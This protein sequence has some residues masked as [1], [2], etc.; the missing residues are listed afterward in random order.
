M[1]AQDIRD[2]L[3]PLLPAGWRVAF[4]LMPAQP[5]ATAG[6]VVV[7]SAGGPS[8]E[9][10]RRPGFALMICGPSGASQLD[11]AAVADTLRGGLIGSAGA[12]DVVQLDCTEPRF[13]LTSDARRVYQMAVEVLANE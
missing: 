3:A 6:Y 10:V 8:G 13:M 12:G 1:I 9:R 7:K 4:E 2:I 5:D 11:V